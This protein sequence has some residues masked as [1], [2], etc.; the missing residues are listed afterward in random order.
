ML[1][2]LKIWQKF[3]LTALLFT[4]PI[5]VLLYLLLIEQ[6]GRINDAKTEKDGLAFIKP[7][8]RLLFDVERN[9]DLV[10]TVLAGDA[11]FKDE[12]YKVTAQID[13]DFAA[14]ISLDK[15]YASFDAH[16]ELKTCADDWNDIR[17]SIQTLNITTSQ[18][19]HNKLVGD[20]MQLGKRVGNASNLLT[21][22]DV[23]TRWIVDALI[24]Q[25]P[26]ITDELSLARLNGMIVISNPTLSDPKYKLAGLT[27]LIGESK[28]ALNGGLKF[29]RDRNANVDNNL[30]GPL[31]GVLQSTQDYVDM[32]NKEIVNS[33]T[34]QM[35]GANYFAASDKVLGSLD[36]THP[37]GFVDFFNVSAKQLDDLLGARI[38]EFNRQ[39]IMSLLAVAVALALTILLLVLVIR[40]VTK[41]INHLSHVAEQISLG[42][43][44]AEIKIDSKDEIGELG[45][46][47]RRLQ[48]SLKAAMDQLEARDTSASGG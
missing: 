43:L 2:R 36:P 25:L 14:L 11:T 20:I 1:K 3:A 33:L 40:T 4:A 27:I 45:E 35:T 17:A 22:P 26:K 6:A 31:T 32:L 12:A 10:G 44:D 30:R 42:E 5:V 28:D 19:K 24:V 9:R 15:Q 38:G 47:F 39:Q 7:V 46:K 23:D 13:T 41:P 37:T 18:D 8:A 48:V 29:A 34:I 21:D 16:A